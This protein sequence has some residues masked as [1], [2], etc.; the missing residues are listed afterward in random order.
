MVVGGAD[1]LGVVWR[2][3]GESGTGSAT[4]SSSAS[5]ETPRA[6]G[7]TSPLPV[8]DRSATA[9]ATTSS[10][11]SVR[12][13]PAPSSAPADGAGNDDASNPHVAQENLRELPE[14]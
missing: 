9:A 3:V 11:D 12:W 1:S 6:T 5:G 8:S 13:P 2:V 10:V 7:V 14:G 4:S